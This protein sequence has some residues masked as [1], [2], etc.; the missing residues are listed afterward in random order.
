MG[1]ELTPEQIARWAP[2]C[3]R[4]GELL[5]GTLAVTESDRLATMIYYRAV[6]PSLNF[7]TDWVRFATRRF[8]REGT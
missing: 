3:P 2:S 5:Y 4:E 6:L 1:T 8:A 7:K